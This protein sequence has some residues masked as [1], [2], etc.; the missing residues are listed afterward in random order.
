MA[1]YAQ[2]GPDKLEVKYIVLSEN[3]HETADFVQKCHDIGVK[4]VSI[5]LDS[6][7]IMFGIPHTLTDEIVEGIA[8]LIYQ[9]KRKGLS[10]YHSGSGYALWQRENGED[11][12]QA[13]LARISAGRFTV[14]QVA[15]GFLGLAKTPQELYHGTIVDWGGYPPE[16]RLAFNLST[17]R[18]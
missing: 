7:P 16:F 13:A 3:A 12:V 1:R 9:A 4:R 14:S 6:R 15:D 2:A 10:V 11:R 8:I 5:D 18:R 17:G